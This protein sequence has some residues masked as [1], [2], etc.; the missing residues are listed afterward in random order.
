MPVARAPAIDDLPSIPL[1]VSAETRLTCGVRG[2]YAPRTPPPVSATVER[3]AAN[4]L[5]GLRGDG[6]S[7][8]AELAAS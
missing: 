7:V 6:A 3:L 4:E 8:A 1:P 2:G 5:T